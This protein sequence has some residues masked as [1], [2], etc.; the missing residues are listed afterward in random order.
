MFHEHIKLNIY[1]M[2]LIICPQYFNLCLDTINSQREPS[3]V[4]TK[5]LLLSNPKN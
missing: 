2:K 3:F 5:N 1:K 4:Q